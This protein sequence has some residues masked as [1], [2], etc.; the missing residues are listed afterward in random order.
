MLLGGILL[1]AWAAAD[2]IGAASLLQE[3]TLVINQQSNVYAFTA[4]A[5][6]TLTIELSDIVWPTALQSLDLSVNSPTSVLGSMSLDGTL[7][8]KVSKGGTFYINVNGDAGGP[9]DI[10]LYSLQV[11]FTPQMAPVPLPEPWALALGGIAL[12]GTLRLLQKRIE[13]EAQPSALTG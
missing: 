12:L 6:G 1:P 4:P 8:I 9:L 3:S 10:G 13:P 5:A 11:G 7:D 2:S